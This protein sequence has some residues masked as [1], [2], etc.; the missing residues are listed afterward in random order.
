MSRDC[1]DAEFRLDVFCDDWL[2]D[3]HRETDAS[4]ENCERF[5][6]ERT[7]GFGE[8]IQ[9]ALDVSIEG[10]LDESRV[11]LSEVALVVVI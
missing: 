2:R 8:G 11:E 3:G 9:K 4:P 10:L 1:A 7:L 5:L 6:E